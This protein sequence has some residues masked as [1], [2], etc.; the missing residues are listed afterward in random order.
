MI[1]K[2]H[3]EQGVLDSGCKSPAMNT[4]APHPPQGSI[5]NCFRSFSD[6]MATVL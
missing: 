6:P 4:L 3:F 5:R 1:W 2:P